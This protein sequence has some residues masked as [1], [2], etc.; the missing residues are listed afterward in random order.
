MDLWLKTGYLKK[1]TTTNN[2]TSDS[3]ITEKFK[4]EHE[5][6]ASQ[7][8]CAKE[9]L[10]ADPC[11]PGTSTSTGNENT[12]KC[13]KLARQYH[14]SYINVGFTWTGEQDEPRPQCVLC[15]AALANKSLK[16]A[17]LQC[18]LETNHAAF[19]DKPLNFFSTNCMS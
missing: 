2:Q 17:N 14:S 1:K 7:H 10:S 18:H 9:I 16:P 13:R 19:K 12:L 3:E 11:L 8:T 5:S 4:I 15:Y 6:T